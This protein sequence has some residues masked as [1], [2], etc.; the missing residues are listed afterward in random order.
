MFCFKDN[1]N[2]ECYSRRSRFNSVKDDWICPIFLRI[3]RIDTHSR[4][5]KIYMIKNDDTLPHLAV[6][7]Q[8]DICGTKAVN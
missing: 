3:T 5:K 6:D 1:H 4:I 7:D 8:R 2:S